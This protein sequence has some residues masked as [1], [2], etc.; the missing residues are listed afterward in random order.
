QHDGIGIIAFGQR[1]ADLLADA[2]ES[3]HLE[4]PAGAAWCADAD[5]P[6]RRVPH[7]LGRRDRRA[8]ASRS[9]DLSDQRSQPGLH[10]WRRAAIDH[11]DFLFVDVDPDHLVARFRQTGGSHGSHVAEPEH[12][13]AHERR[14]PRI[15]LR[16]LEPLVTMS[17]A[18]PSGDVRR[19]PAL[20]VGRDPG[21]A[22]RP[23]PRTVPDRLPERN[24]CPG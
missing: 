6:D 16:T 14:A 8:Q 12:V 22:R 13:N 5:E 10:D 15:W 20:D 4:L 3:V 9:H 23:S 17:T 7:S 1:L 18:P 11:G 2:L 21:A 19:Y 24:A